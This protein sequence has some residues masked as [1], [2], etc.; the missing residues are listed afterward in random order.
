MIASSWEGNMSIADSLFREAQAIAAHFQG[1]ALN[2]E[3]EILDLEAQLQTKK[4]ALYTARMASKRAS[5]F[6]PMFGADF[7]CPG[8]WVEK[9]ENATLRPIPGDAMRCNV[10]DRLF[11]I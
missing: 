8:C 3:R 11:A 1:T 7:Y 9:E 6:R 10:C 2:L 4:A 5:N